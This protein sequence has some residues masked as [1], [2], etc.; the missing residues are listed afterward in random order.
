LRGKPI[1]FLVL[2]GNI[3]NAL[4]QV[5]PPAAATP[6]VSINACALNLTFFPKGR[7]DSNIPVG[8]TQTAQFAVNGGSED[9]MVMIALDG[10]PA[11]VI[12][13]APKYVL[14]Q[15]NAVVPDQCLSTPAAPGKQKKVLVPATYTVAYTLNSSAPVTLPGNFGG[16]ST[17]IANITLRDLQSMPEGDYCLSVTITVVK[18]TATVAS[19]AGEDDVLMPAKD[20]SV[21]R[22]VCFIKKV[23]RPTG[24]PSFYSCDK[25]F[26]VGLDKLSPLPRDVALPGGKDP[27][28]IY[29][30]RFTVAGKLNRSF[31][32]TIYPGDA[33]TYFSVRDQVDNQ[34][35]PLTSSNTTFLNVT[36]PDAGMV[37]GWYDVIVEGGLISNF[38]SLVS[39]A[40]SDLYDDGLQKYMG[41]ALNGGVSYQ[42]AVQTKESS[43]GEVT[44]EPSPARLG[45]VVVFN[46]VLQGNGRLD[47]YLDDVPVNQIV[48][49]AKP[50]VAPS[51]LVTDGGINDTM[52]AEALLNAPTTTTPTPPTTTT[53]PTTATTPGAA[54]KNATAMSEGVMD[55]TMNTTLPTGMPATSA[56]KASGN[57]TAV[58]APT[59][60]NATAN[61]TTNATAKAAANATLDITNQ[62]KN[63]AQT[64][65]RSSPLATA[66]ASSTCRAPFEYTIKDTKNH[67]LRMVFTD[68]CG[69]RIIKL[70]RFNANGFYMDPKYEPIMESLG[71]F[72]ATGPVVTPAN[73]TRAPVRSGAEGRSQASLFVVSIFS[74]LVMKLVMSW[75]RAV[76]ARTNEGLGARG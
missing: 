27:I 31:D 73:R 43:L 12:N 9:T 52:I 67:T 7:E 15:L 17:K 41:L 35:Y 14:T 16:S 63:A 6:N 10:Y 57:V 8:W 13:V 69:N 24:V 42:V 56:P 74:C 50:A 36:I 59:S 5:A 75:Y 22:K 72:N 32:G 76:D 46:W 18:G 4:A 51:L 48:P 65:A 66:N 71:D 23:E 53:T 33:V 20:E 19:T 3:I 45:E 58:S 30:P 61:A 1:F 11:P 2:I 54:P 62:I 55:A 26:R 68:V 44:M 40:G 37:D 28:T 34:V 21:T 47:C 70:V 39:L 64:G 60:G 29:S 25:G 49:I 38:P